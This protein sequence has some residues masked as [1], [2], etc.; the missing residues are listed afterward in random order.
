MNC[1][2]CGAAMVLLGARRYYFCQHCGSFHFPGTID[3]G[4]RVTP[5]APSSANCAVCRKPMARALLDDEHQAEY[6][7]NCRGVLLPRRHFAEIVRRRRSWASSPPVTPEP[8]DR[9]ELER[10]VRCPSC[11]RQMQTHPYYG[12]GNVVIQ[13]CDACDL[14]WLD[15]GE[16]QQIVDA[17][18]GDR[19]NR[20]LPGPRARSHRSPDETD[21]SGAPASS[22]LD[23]LFDLLS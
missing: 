11:S 16:L 17:P 3:E 6:C 19:G 15:H 14:V 1:A 5:G 13:T 22:S 23:Q 2:N 18:G 20:E 8:L 12:P 4:V 9:R 7:Q 21:G 10:V